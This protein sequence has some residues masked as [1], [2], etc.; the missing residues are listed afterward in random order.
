MQ[1]MILRQRNSSCG[2]YRV[3]MLDQDTKILGGGKKTSIV[4]SPVKPL[5]GSPRLITC[6]VPIECRV[7]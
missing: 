4:D 6:L 3:D 2:P 5:N 7:L 1:R